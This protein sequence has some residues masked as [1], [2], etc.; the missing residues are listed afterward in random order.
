MLFM[1][2]IGD[3]LFHFGYR[4]GVVENKIRKCRF[5]TSGPTDPG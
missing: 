3:T 2:S 5:D 1:G 4:L